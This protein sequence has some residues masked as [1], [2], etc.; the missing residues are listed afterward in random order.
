MTL[1]RTR[2]ELWWCAILVSSLSVVCCDRD[3]APPWALREFDTPAWAGQEGLLVVKTQTEDSNIL[4]LRHR[5]PEEGTAE[6]FGEIHPEPDYDAG[7]VMYRYDPSLS[8]DKLEVIDLREWEQATGP[9]WWDIQQV[10]RVPGKMRAVQGMGKVRYEAN[11]ARTKG[12]EILHMAR[13]MWPGSQKV[14]ILSGVRKRADWETERQWGGIRLAK[15][16]HQV[17]DMERLAMVGQPIRL[18]FVT[19]L[20]D[21]KGVWAG[22]D[23]YVV[24]TTSLHKRVV[25]VHVD[26]RVLE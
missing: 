21:V 22:R 8:P 7:E 17:Y 14:A 11:E 18:P 13:S 4:L 16:Y 1:A 12:S 23:T 25:I 5:P 3:K 24:Y 20:G 6:L 9:L 15:Y 2:H 19:D 10:R 26:E